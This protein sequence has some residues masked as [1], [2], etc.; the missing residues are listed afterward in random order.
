MGRPYSQAQDLSA[1]CGHA[2]VSHRA[3]VP[4]EALGQ[5]VHTER[6]ERWHQMRVSPRPLA[7]LGK[8]PMEGGLGLEDAKAVATPA[9]GERPWLAEED[10]EKLGSQE[11]REFR[12]LAARANHLALDRIDIQYAV[13][14]ACRGMAEPTKRDLRKLRRL[15]RYLKGRPRLVVDF[16]WQE[17]CGVVKAMSDSDWAGCR[18]TAKS[19]SGGVIMR[20]AHYLV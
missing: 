14:E 20:G 9:E 8:A 18:R 15:G 19:T 10:E 2:C 13:K 7:S 11:A 16:K 17:P 1:S 3:G 4:L 12:G 5:H 6:T